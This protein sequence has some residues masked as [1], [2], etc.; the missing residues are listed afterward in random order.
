TNGGMIVI[1]GTALNLNG[2]AL[3][4][5]ASAGVTGSGTGTGNG[6]T[7]NVTTSGSGSTGQI[8]VGSGKLTILATGGEATSSGG[9]GGSVRLSSGGNIVVDPAFLTA[10]PL[11]Q[12]GG[13]AGTSKAK[14]DTQAPGIKFTAGT[15]GQGTLQ[16]TGNL[17]ASGG[18]AN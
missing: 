1:A 11:G 3:T 10:G 16:L 13:G 12:N 8:N 18:G 9:D 2:Q 14:L 4:L 6:G 17:D 5:N 7:V 15:N